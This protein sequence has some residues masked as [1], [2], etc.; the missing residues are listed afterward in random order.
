MHISWH[1]QYSV[2]IG[3]KDTTLVL[4][5]YAPDTGLPALRAKAD[6]VALSNPTDQSMSHLAGIQG[7]PVVVDSPGEYSI[8]GLTLYAFPWRSDGDPEKS[9]HRWDIDGVAILHLGA[10][11]RDLTDLE[12]SN[13]ERTD[14]DVLLLPVGG[15]TGLSTE[16]AL[17]LVTTIEPRVV[18]PIHFALPGLKEKL[19]GVEKFAK[20]M[21]VNPSKKEKKVIIKSSKLPHDDIQ[22]ILLQP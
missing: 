11:N 9:L 19:D 17:A 7:E 8:R 3:T 5:P 13:I 21:G 22:T 1:G 4:D 2:K 10:L 16:K 14:I 12:L 6:V 20:Q 15:G 18:I